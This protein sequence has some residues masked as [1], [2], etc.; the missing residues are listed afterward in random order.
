MRLCVKKSLQK[1]NSTQKKTMTVPKE[2]QITN[3]PNGKPEEGDQDTY[4][5]Q[6]P[7]DEN[8]NP[9]KME[10]QKHS[11]QNGLEEVPERGH[12]HEYKPP[13]SD[14]EKVNKTQ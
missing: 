4:H 8:G 3:V 12:Q 7:Y 11:N 14:P 5:D 2:N 6:N 10:E 1:N 13:I 9:N